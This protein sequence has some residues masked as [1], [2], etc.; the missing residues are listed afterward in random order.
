M[1]R[2]C[3]SFDVSITHAGAPCPRMLL[4]GLCLL[5]FSFFFCLKDEFLPSLSSEG[6]PS[7]CSLTGGNIIWCRVIP[8]ESVY[9]GATGAR[10]ADGRQRAASASERNSIS[11]WRALF[12]F[13]TQRHHF[14]N[15]TNVAAGR[16][17]SIRLL[18]HCVVTKKTKRAV[19]FEPPNPAHFSYWPAELTRKQCCRLFREAIH[20][21]LYQKSLE[22][23]NRCYLNIQSA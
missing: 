13:F 23:A 22:V 18:L 17:N 19:I 3:S 14:F 21:W 6:L 5:F 11:G 12:F 20:Y 10:T 4:S 7:W 16:M 2:H 8:Q 1:L 15:A 9:G